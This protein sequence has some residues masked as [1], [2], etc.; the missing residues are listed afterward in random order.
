MCIRNPE[1][2]ETGD[3]SYR[4]FFDFDPVFLAVPRL[5]DFFAALRFGFDAAVFLGAFR[6]VAA[7]ALGFVACLFALAVFALGDAALTLGRVAF[8]GRFLAAAIAAPDSA[9]IAVPTIGMPSAVPATAPATAPPRVLLVA[10]ETVS[11][12]ALSLS[13]SM[14]P[15]YFRGKQRW[16]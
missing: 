10:P 8:V 2:S 7:F 12:V 6:A 3:L 5:T 9:P 1:L 15:S 16:L 14:F 13:S 4:D 11:S